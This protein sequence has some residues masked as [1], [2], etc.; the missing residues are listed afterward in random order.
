M[1]IAMITPHYQPAVRGNAVTVRRIEK[2]IGA[3]GHEVRVYSLDVM[4]VEEILTQVSLFAPDLMH[5]FH[6]YLGG[7]VVRL[8]QQSTGIPYL[9]TLTGSDVYEALDD[10]RKGETHA[11]LRDAFALAVFHQSMRMRIE[12]HFPSMVQKTVVIAQGVEMPGDISLRERKFPFPEGTFTFLLPA[13]VRPV[14]NVLFP[15]APLG[16][17][18]EHDP[19]LR[20]LLAGPVLDSGY[21]A[22]VMAG[23]ERCPFAG[24]L[25]E[26]GHHDMGSLYRRADVVV[27]SSIFEGGMANSVLEALAFGKPVLAANIEG[28]RSLIKDGTTGLLYRDEGDFKE[29][30][31]RLLTDAK[32]RERLAGNGHGMVLEQFR[33]EAEADAYLALYETVMRR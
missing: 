26:I 12:Q 3:R 24:Y 9:I 22:E 17:L 14:K 31:L 16:A 32:L 6:G 33:P 5:A 1:R 15:L 25:G 23:F 13:G 20:F 19:R 7:R 8:I 11:A 27:N 28:N 18:Y 4:A 10:G 29:K 21:A 2:H 30:A